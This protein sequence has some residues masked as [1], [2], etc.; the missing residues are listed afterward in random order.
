MESC[1]P[2]KCVHDQD[3]FRGQASISFEI[4]DK[5]VRDKSGTLCCWIRYNW[6]VSCY[7]ALSI[8][9]FL[10]GI[11]DTVSGHRF[12]I[13][14]IRYI[15]SEEHQFSNSWLSHG[16]YRLKYATCQLKYVTYVRKVRSYA[17]NSNSGCI[18]IYLSLE[19]FRNLK[20]KFSNSTLFRYLNSNWLHCTNS[21]VLLRLREC[22]WDTER[23][24]NRTLG[25]D[26]SFI[27]LLI[28]FWAVWLEKDKIVNL[29][30]LVPK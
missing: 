26:W 17:Q 12:P 3:K 27:Y 29:R 24:N 11:P 5:V 7:Q 6:M 22:P 13:S 19:G 30:L 1:V 14:C 23:Q 8:L 10:P 18:S 4:M 15:S 25:K 2:D 9:L 20:K 16:A 21:S 28:S